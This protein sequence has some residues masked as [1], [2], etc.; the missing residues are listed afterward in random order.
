LNASSEGEIRAFEDFIEAYQNRFYL[1]PLTTVIDFI[2]LNRFGEIDP[3]IS[4]RFVPL[5]SMDE[6]ER[7]EVDKI[8]AEADDLRINGG[9]IHPIEARKSVANDPNSRY[10]GI[11]VN[12]LPIPPGEGEVDDD[13]NNP[14][15]NPPELIGGAGLD[16][17]KPK[18]GLKDE[19]QHTD[20]NQAATENAG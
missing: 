19:H 18:G 7:A 16:P 2:Q 13:P 6:K 3:E 20:D 1:E 10:Q 9:V 11:E 8:N 15:G 12:D 5:H 14:E 4:F 17:G